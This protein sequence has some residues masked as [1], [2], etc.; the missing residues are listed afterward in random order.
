MSK[1]SD[2]CGNQLNPTTDHTVEENKESDQAANENVKGEHRNGSANAITVGNEPG[3][4]FLNSERDANQQGQQ[5]VIARSISLINRLTEKCNARCHD[6]W[7]KNM[8]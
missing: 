1:H 2:H 7:D 5:S 4:H 8:L 6:S 3:N